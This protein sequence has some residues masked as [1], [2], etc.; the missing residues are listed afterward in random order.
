MTTLTINSETT[1]QAAIGEI[2]ELWRAKRLHRSEPIDLIVV[3]HIHDFKINA[4][5]ARFE[6]GAIA[7]SVKNL[8]RQWNIP[9]VALAQLNRNVTGRADKRPT[10]ADLRESGELEQKGDLILFLHREDYYDGPESQTHLQGVVECHI[11]KG[12]DIEAG[13]RINLRNAYA[14]MRLEDWE[15]PWPIAPIEQPRE[16]RTR[17]R[18]SGLSGK[19]RSAS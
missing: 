11:A 13:K 1:L 17:S 5:E 19:D 6:I 4:K 2:R 9:G 18:W 3:D 7:Q 10:L 16:Q 12:R 14:Q 8:A 15:G